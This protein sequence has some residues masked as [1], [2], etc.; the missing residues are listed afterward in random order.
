MNLVWSKPYISKRI[1]NGWK[2]RFD[3]CNVD[4]T[5]Y[6]AVQKTLSAVVVTT[7][8]LYVALYVQHR[9]RCSYWPNFLGATLANEDGANRPWPQIYEHI[10]EAFVSNTPFPNVTHL[11]RTRQDP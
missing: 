5:S 11:K 10:F 6:S 2:P 4:L 3:V 7:V 9:M 1:K 8:Y